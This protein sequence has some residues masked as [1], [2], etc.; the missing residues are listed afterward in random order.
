MGS[1]SCRLEVVLP[2]GRG[3]LAAAF[4]TPRPIGSRYFF[5]LTVVSRV[6]RPGV[7]AGRSIYRSAFE[8]P[9][10]PFGGAISR[11]LRGLTRLAYRRVPAACLSRLR[12]G[13]V[14]GFV[15]VAAR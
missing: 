14:F 5:L 9:A 2:A 3:A 1:R 10:S 12:V 7:Y 4:S 11:V 8:V 15:L 6:W 13:D